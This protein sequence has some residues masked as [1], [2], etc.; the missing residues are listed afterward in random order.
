MEDSLV[1]K[2]KEICKTMDHLIDEDKKFIINKSKLYC[3]YCL[4]LGKD[5]VNSIANNFYEECEDYLKELENYLNNRLEM[6][7]IE[8]DFINSY[9]TNLAKEGEKLCKEI[10][11]NIEVC[12]EL[13]VNKATTYCQFIVSKLDSLDPKLVERCKSYL[14]DVNNFYRYESTFK[15]VNNDRRERKSWLDMRHMRLNGI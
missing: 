4:S 10:E 1:E 5:E 6:K 2:G 15:Q 7:Q 3:K 8:N 13:L 14:D 9:E 11:N 12:G